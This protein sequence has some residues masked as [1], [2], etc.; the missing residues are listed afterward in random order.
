MANLNAFSGLFMGSVQKFCWM[1]SL[2]MFCMNVSMIRLSVWSPKSRFAANPVRVYQTWPNVSF[3]F[4]FREKFLYLSRI[5]FLGLWNACS[6]FSTISLRE[7]VATRMWGNLSV[8]RFRA[9]DPSDKNSTHT[10]F[11]SAACSLRWFRNAAT[12]GF[13]SVTV[14]SIPFTDME[15]LALAAPWKDPTIPPIL[16]RCCACRIP[17]F[18]QSRHPRRF[19]RSWHFCAGWQFSQRHVRDDEKETNLCDNVEL[20]IDWFLELDHVATVLFFYLF[21]HSCCLSTTCTFEWEEW[22]YC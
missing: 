7:I 20:L 9:A 21:E 4:C 13:Y 10:I 3:E 17:E 12:I 16:F 18:C 14:L 5:Q 8:R 2:F 11:L 22:W 6:Q 19:L 15:Y 1:I